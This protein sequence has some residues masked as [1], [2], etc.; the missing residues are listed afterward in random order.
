MALKRWAKRLIAVAALCAG[1]GVGAL[2]VIPCTAYPF[3][4]GCGPLTAAVLNESFATVTAAAAA[5]AGAVNVVSYGAVGNG[6]VDDTSALA[7]AAAS[8]LPLYIPAGTY[9]ITNMITWSTGQVVRGAGRTKSIISVPATFNMSALGVVRMGT[10]EPGAT[11]LDIGIEFT[12]PDATAKASMTAYPPAIY[13]VAAPR[14]ILD[15]IRIS[16]AYDGIK[17]TGN[18]GGAYI[19]FVEVGAINKGIQMGGALDFVHGG[20]WHIW[21]FGFTSTN[22]LTAWAAAGVTGFTTTEMDGVEIGSIAAFQAKLDFLATAATL[23]VQIG[24]VSLDGNGSG[25]TDNYFSLMI[26]SLYTTKDT[27]SVAPSITAGIGSNI[28]IGALDQSVTSLSDDIVVNSASARL[29]IN[30]GDSIQNSLAYSAFA[31]SDGIL[32]L[33][34]IRMKHAPSGTRTSATVKQTGGALRMSGN[35]WSAKSA[36]V[37][38]ALSVAGDAAL[39]FIAN[40]DFVDWTVTLPATI[41]SGEYGPNKITAFT[42]TSSVAFATNGDFTPTYTDRA[43]AYE[44]MGSGVVWFEGYMLFDTNGF[45]TAAGA[46]Q[47]ATGLPAAPTRDTA[48]TIG[49]LAKITFGSAVLSG[50]VI[51]TDSKILLREITSNAALGSMGTTHILPSKTGV[52]IRISGTYRYR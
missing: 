42:A 39:N 3:T 21:P 45:S 36:V 2:A 19:G 27:G 4:T 52:L 46:F 24:R 12:Q 17:A 11:M 7:A 32:E 25:L 47:Y 41:A 9:K 6:I 50:A 49:D 40:N 37:G 15:R 5:A 51:G 35:Q 29:V 8:G 31:V 23:P 44:F 14:F 22:R 20:H 1:G 13:A 30:S 43:M 10:S 38:S 26:G 48:V 33:H 16:G 18:S 28:T 34:N